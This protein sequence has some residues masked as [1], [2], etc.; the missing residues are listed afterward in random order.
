M[1]NV[2]NIENEQNCDDLTGDEIYKKIKY[3]LSNTDT[4][5]ENIII[6]CSH[7]KLTCQQE[8]ELV[9][10]QDYCNK[11]FKRYEN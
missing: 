2:W 8:D 6:C 3:K 9:D 11:L 10:Y 7:P 5:K 4:S 1:G